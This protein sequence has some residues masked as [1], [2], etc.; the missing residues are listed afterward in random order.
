V[1]VVEF[2]LE[3][4]PVGDGPVRAVRASGLAL[5]DLPALRLPPFARDWLV[6]TFL[7]SPDLFDRSLVDLCRVAGVAGAPVPGRPYFA[8]EPGGALKLFA[9][10]AV[11]RAYHAALLFAPQRPTPEG[12][13]ALGIVPEDHWSPKR[14]GDGLYI[15][16]WDRA[17]TL[18]AESRDLRA[19][20]VNGIFRLATE[21]DEEHVAQLRVDLDAHAARYTIEEG[22]EGLR[23]TRV[24]AHGASRL[25]EH[26]HDTP[27]GWLLEATPVPPGADA[28][29]ARGRRRPGRLRGWLRR[30]L[31]TVVGFPVIVLVRAALLPPSAARRVRRMFR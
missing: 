18:F 28:G 6:V 13:D 15:E 23:L 1:G 31:Q 16:C 7:E 22:P 10:R 8:A 26:F 9:T 17:V 27:E 12:L 3:I 2:D 24:A 20:I 29:R 30:T 5:E 21:R 25:P 4:R 14:L 11:Q 19:R